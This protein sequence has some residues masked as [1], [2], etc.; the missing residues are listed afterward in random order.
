MPANEKIK[1]KG[2]YFQFFTQS[3]NTPKQQIFSTGLILGERFILWLVRGRKENL[4]LHFNV[5]QASICS[6]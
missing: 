1:N 6:C 3:K 2:F 4:N 5:W